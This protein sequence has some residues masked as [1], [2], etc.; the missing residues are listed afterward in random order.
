MRLLLHDPQ[1]ALTALREEVGPVCGIG[2][3]PM[4]LAIVG[5]PDALREMFA[6]PND[7]F[8][9]GHKFNV[10]GFVVGE[11]SM[12][13]SDG[14]DH[15]RRRSA[16][17]SAFS[18]KRLNQWIP[19]I[20][21]RTD[22]AIDSLLATARDDE[23]VD[24]YPIGRSLV[25]D[26][27]T[28]ALFGSRLAPR[29][30]EIGARF[31]RPQQYLESSAIRQF[32]HPFPGTRR[33]RVRADRAAID[34]IVDDAIR[35]CRNDP[36]HD[37]LDVLDALVRDGTLNDAEIRDQIVTLV[38]A[39]YDT[40]AA[41]LSWMLWCCA[42]HPDV[43][44]RLRDEAD[45]MLN[46]GVPDETSLRSLIEARCVMQET[47]RMLPVGAFAPREAHRDLVVAG[48]RIP[49]GTLIMWSAFLAGRD[50][51]MWADP[52]T[53]DPRRFANADDAQRAAA[54]YAWIPFG[55]G[56]RNCIGFALAQ[57]ELTLII[58]RLAQRINIQP[59]RDELPRPTGMVVNR[60]AGGAP[61]LISARR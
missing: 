59:I 54:D 61:M 20:V 21:E 51:S 30:Q 41:T 38:G 4:K 29:A 34:R 32:P 1:P 11:G 39:G 42:L 50:P 40:T 37:S 35:Q 57:M 9:W 46:G 17:Q 56:A 60:P 45:V 8:R 48:Y 55:R 15:K 58:A 24:M 44:Q 49:K 43:W 47:T 14:S 16:V 26:I 36:E 25:L 19:M 52:L 7:A 12:I 3:G 18:V 31:E 53:W 33:S 28:R 23:P 10:L 2:G 27:V 22:A 5:D 6:M 13:V